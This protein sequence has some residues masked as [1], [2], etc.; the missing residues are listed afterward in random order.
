MRT[1]NFL[2]NRRGSQMSEIERAALEATLGPSKTFEARKQLVQQGALVSNSILLIDGFMCRYMDD[3]N[4]HRQLVALHIPGDF[5]D[6]HG[7]P[8]KKLDHDVAT[9]TKVTVAFAAHDKLTEATN[10]HPH[11]TRMLWFSTL[12][13]AAMHRE[14]IFRLGRLDALGRIAHFLAETNQRLM[15][16]GLS[17]GQVFRLP[18]TQTD[19]AEACG[20]TNIHAN[21][22][23]GEL[24]RREIADF[25]SQTVRIANIER[26]HEVAEFDPQ[27]LYLDDGVVI[28]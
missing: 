22:M 17:D 9:I 18:M 20:L 1:A 2:R 5:V 21:R 13:E 23:I 3:R 7:Y 12:L 11:L 16:V 28:P 27:Y 15:A 19:I 6:L 10:E 24:R 14:W 4:G 25:S 8:L 26:L